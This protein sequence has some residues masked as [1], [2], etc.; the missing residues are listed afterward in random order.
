MSQHKAY[1]S[2]VLDAPAGLVWALIR[3]FN[4]LP[5]WHPAI[6]DSLIE[7]GRAPDSVGCVRSFHLQ[8][9]AHIREK[10]LALDEQAMSVTYDF[11]TSPI[12][13]RNYLATLRLTPVTKGHRTFAEWWAT[14]DCDPGQEA[15]LTPLFRDGVFKA[16]FDA[17]ATRLAGPVMAAPRELWPEGPPAKVFCSD[18]IA[19]PPAAVWAV[20]RDFAGMGGWHPDITRMHMLDGRRSDEVGATRDFYVGDG[21]LHEQLTQLCD[22]TMSFRYRITMSPMPWTRYSAGPTLH[23]IVDGNRTFAVWTADWHAAPHD[24]A[25]LMPL[26]HN[27]VFQKAFDTLN[28]RFAR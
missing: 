11:Q 3:D 28:A 8:D 12:P 24:D 23:P 13:A 26:V 15:E 4:A 18:V 21:R 17:L 16:G 1:Y 6:R 22:R 2:T 5:A 7:E 19:A 14:Y 20:M 10:L 9:G 25:A 27:D